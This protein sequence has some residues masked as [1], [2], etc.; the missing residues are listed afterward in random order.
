MS[1]PGSGSPLLLAT[2]A[3][4]AAAEY[5]IPKSLRFNDPDTASLSKTFSSAGN[6]KTW[7]WSC[8]AKRGNDD[9]SQL[10][11]SANNGSGS[12]TEIR[13]KDDTIGIQ[14]N[15]I[16]SPN[17]WKTNAVF[18]DH[19][20]WYHIVCAIDTT[21]ATASSRI[22]VYVNG[23]EQTFSQ[24]P[25][26]TQNSDLYVNAAVSHSIGKRDSSSTSNFD[27][28]LADIQFVDGQALA[29]SDFG[30][31]RSS[32]GVWVPKEASFTSPNDGTT[33]S[34]STVTTGTID[35][36][37]PL[38]N[39]FNGSIAQPNTRSSGANTT[40]T[41]TLT[42]AISFSSKV[43]IY[44]NQNGTANINSESTV[45][46]SSGGGS[47][48][49]VF[50]G[51]GSL[52]SLTL[53]STGGDTVSL[54]AIE[55]DGVILQDGL[56]NKY[57]VNG[58]HLNFSDNSTNEALGFDS[59]PTIPDADPKKGM[60][61]V[62]WTGTGSTQNI[63][64]LNFEPGLVWIKSTDNA[65]DHH[66]YDSIR[67]TT[68]A[69]FSNR[70]NA[71]T[72]YSNGFTSF[73]PDGFTL[74]GELGHN[75]SSKNY[76]AWTWRA[77]GPAVANSDGTITSQ[78]SA[79]TDYGFSIVSYTGTGSN[80]TIGHGLNTTP[81]FIIAKTRDSAVNWIIYHGSLGSQD[82]L[83]FTTAVKDNNSTVWNTAP[84]SS[85]F[86]V[87][88][89]NGVNQSG[90]D[91]IA[92]CWSEVSGYSKFGSYTGGSGTQSITGLGFKPRFVILKRTDSTSDWFILDSE[93]GPDSS[94]QLYANNNLVE[95]GGPTISFDA[96]GFTF[97]SYT[98]SANTSGGSYIY[99]AFA[100]RPGNNFDVNN[101]VTNEGL[102]TSKSQF[103]VVTYTGTGSA[104]QIGGP[105]YSAHATNP[106]SYNGSAANLFNG[107]LS[108][109]WQNT[110]TSGSTY[111]S[112][113][114]TRGGATSGV[115][116]TT[117][118]EMY[119][120]FS[121]NQVLEIVHAGGTHTYNSFPGGSGAWV[122]FTSSLTSP[123]TTVRYKD[124]GGTGT[125]SWNA[126]RV[127]NEIL[128]DGDD[129]P[130][131]KFQPDLVWI[132][133]RS[134]SS[135]GHMLFDSVRGPANSLYSQDSG[136][137][138]HPNAYGKLNSF[139][140]DGFTVAP[141]SS[142]STN[143][144]ANNATYVAWC[145]N[146]GD[147][148]IPQ[149]YGTAA[150][151]SSTAALSTTLIGPAAIN[152]DS[153]SINYQNLDI[154]LQED[155][156]TVS[157]KVKHAA[158]PITYLVSADGT[159]WT[160][161]STG[162][163]MAALSTI[164]ISHSSAFRYVRFHYP[165]GNFGQAFQVINNT[166]GSLV[167][168][169]KANSQYGFSVVSY[170]G[171]GSAATV[172]H[173]LTKPPSL[174]IVKQRDGTDSWAVYSE[175]TGASGY[176]SIEDTSATK[177]NVAPFNGTDPT[178][179]VFSIA[180]AS[181]S[182]AV[183]R[184]NLSGK[185]YLAY[186]FANVPGYQRIGSYTGNGSSTGPV[187]PTG[188][189]PRFLIVKRTDSTGAWVMLDSERNPTNP[190]TKSF[191]ADVSDAEYTP[192]QNWA[193]FDESSFQLTATYGEVNASGGTYVYLAIGDDEIG[194]DEDCLVDVPNA[195]TADAD[196]TDTT[197]G[198]QRGNYA[199]INPLDNPGES[200][201][202]NQGASISNGNLD[203]AA[204]GS[205]YAMRR[206]TVQI[207]STGKWYMECTVNGT[208]ASRSS[209]S[210]ASG[211]GLCK[212]NVITDGNAPITD[213]QTMWLGDSGYGL[214]FT[215]T[216]V[217]WA[218]TTV[219]NGDVISLAL[220][221]GAN[222]FDFMVNGVSVQ[223]GTIGTTDP[224]H[225]FVFSSS[226]SYT[227]LS[228]NFGQMRFKY[229]MPSGYAALN[230]T[231]LPAATIADGSA[232]FD[233]KLYTGTGSTQQISGLEF[234]P[235]LV[236][237]KKRNAATSHQLTDTV[238]GATKFVRANT[239][240]AEVTDANTLSAFN[241]DG[242]TVGSDAATNGSSDTFVSWNWNAGSSTVSNTDGSITSNVRANASAGF[243]IV[244][245]TGTGS[246]ATVGHGLNAQPGLV[247]VKNRTSTASWAVWHT[248]LTGSQFLGLNTENAVQSSANYWN[249]T[250][251]TAS[252]FSVGS[253]SSANGS[254]KN[255]IAY[256]FAPVAGFSAFG[257]HT[258]T[259]AGSTGPFNYC[260]FRPALVVVKRT[261]STGWWSVWDTKRDPD[262]TAGKNVWWNDTY[263]E[264]DSSQYKIDILSNGF[265]M[266]SGHAERNASGGT[267]VW[268]AFAEN[269]FQANG[270]LAR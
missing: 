249:S 125:P 206:A 172:G 139:N 19:S 149:L 262:N 132:K 154:D 60:D 77:G 84:T 234:S 137:E 15:N 54:M 241:S 178:S 116:F 75:G 35:S 218:G 270:G 108:T 121:Y 94:D 49:T 76:V 169:V 48:I 177:T 6:R 128:I 119:G 198:Y 74:G 135:Y 111:A 195:V 66:L 202:G 182:D 46:T 185:E 58:F 211:F 240:G 204:D 23:V 103:D 36:S 69:L 175:P 7:T 113:D 40:I 120:A 217:D 199:T 171:T 129:G 253:D 250:V 192:G 251:P 233:V 107:D 247:L 25:T 81:K 104:Q 165:N 255:M 259:G 16:A 252:V 141:G 168:T 231:A 52:T 264:I 183:N 143:V 163:N 28:L 176:L 110:D 245:W 184:V 24:S 191:Y 115:A 59:A 68:K 50:T 242:F 44:Q 215:G 207:P 267:Y 153:E 188:F 122:D 160:S 26:V 179:S 124:S 133:S 93:R 226:T 56:S 96:D 14:A 37:Y 118:F 64:G 88:S 181:G 3:A 29:G 127:D 95:Q 210:Q 27:G 239:S 144:N 225:P 20:A 155:V 12:Y 42:K 80:A 194:S 166:D 53:T 51:S 187:I 82:F 236:W 159:N 71:E 150:T 32:D 67:G 1:I 230:T 146:A 17:E 10:L 266:R 106:S 4:A 45:S 223:T 260:G 157:I 55:V 79:N 219:D 220:D 2:T 130:G 11:L 268:L 8:W 174:I 180:A 256:C 263:Y 244:S 39:A 269:P 131:L 152:A 105:S 34:N 186:C 43:R 248:S 85:V 224:V 156:T 201:Y 98:G 229:P 112:V 238:R 261:D 5:V 65:Y 164:T 212:S 142:D 33:W 197:G 30:E 213:S 101:I 205:S 216:R 123:V 161:K 102:S 237:L 114:L 158:S 72:T 145:W 89:A 91:Y 13:F 86:G 117:S 140:S 100:D 38:T 189:K 227:N 203:F 167:S 193:D 228:V 31:T 265:R 62:T 200:P 90:D 222:T 21:N 92:Y 47:W 147:A 9:S 18:R 126:I 190:R 57:G 63:G 78:V 257:K 162:N 209:S 99:I 138:G 214:N 221:M 151:V 246:N 70:T 173:G 109:S 235:D 208:A 258:G 61:V 232:H 170:L 136:A 73:N 134:S 254:S 196:A 83:R 87:G 41:I 243:S 97:Q 22:K 148:N